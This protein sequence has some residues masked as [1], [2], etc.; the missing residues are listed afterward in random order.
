MHKNI[1]R[2][3]DF[4]RIYFNSFLGAI[5]SICSIAGLVMCF[6]NDKTAII[7]ALTIVII[8]LLIIQKEVHLVLSFL[9]L[10]LC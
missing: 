1:K 10:V 7:I 2:V 3:F 5:G 4:F 9:M 6:S 8:C